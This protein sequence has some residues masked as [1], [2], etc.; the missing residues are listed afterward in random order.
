LE[1]ISYTYNMDV[2]YLA[3]D[4]KTLTDAMDKYTRWIEENLK[5]A[6]EDVDQS[7]D[8]VQFPIK[9]GFTANIL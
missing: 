7:V 8:Q 6:L 9:K 4:E 1:T 5:T 3:P 2:Y